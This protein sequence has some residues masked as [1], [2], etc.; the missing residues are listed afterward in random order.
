MSAWELATAASAISAL[1]SSSLCAVLVFSI[2]LQTHQHLLWGF[3]NGS[4]PA[5][6]TSDSSGLLKFAVH[7]HMRLLTEQVK[8]KVLV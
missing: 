4:P 6:E 7:K 8:H 5:A 2:A 1:L 3:T